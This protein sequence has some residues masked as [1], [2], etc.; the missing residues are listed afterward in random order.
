MVIFRPLN[1]GL[2]VPVSELRSFVHLDVLEELGGVQ[3]A[4][5]RSAGDR[6]LEL[7]LGLS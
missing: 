6:E 3:E 1:A 4:A 5:N 2:A 7:I